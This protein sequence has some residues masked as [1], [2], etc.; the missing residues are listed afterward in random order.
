MAGAFPPYPE[1]A[2]FASI[3]H[4]MVAKD[5]DKT[6][7]KLWGEE[8]GA[9]FFILRG[10]HAVSSALSVATISSLVRKMV[11]PTTK[12]LSV[13]L[14]LSGID[15]L[16]FGPPVP[17][18]WSQLPRHSA[19]HSDIFIDA[20]A[21][22][23]TYGTESS[24]GISATRRRGLLEKIRTIQERLEEFTDHHAARLDPHKVDVERRIADA[25][26]ADLKDFL[27]V[28]RDDAEVLRQSH[29][30]LAPANGLR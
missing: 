23:K 14:T 9:I 7:L 27:G 18:G 3:S 21:I 2:G 5:A 28:L 25:I 24:P 30:F 12:M 29:A 19:N 10:G 6:E 20:L 16:A 8:G 17:E 1:N 11:E 13:L 22:V 4:S 15:V 26:N